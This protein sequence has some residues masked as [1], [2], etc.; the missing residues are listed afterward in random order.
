MYFL[1]DKILS[2]INKNFLNPSSLTLFI[3]LIT[4]GISLLKYL[5]LYRHA[6][7]QNAQLLGQPLPA[8]TG[9]KSPIFLF[10]TN[11]YLGIG[12]TNL[13]IFLE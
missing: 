12:V 7:E 6:I 11:S 9:R 1:S 3:S 5:P 10:V 13:S 4:S 8:C 2:S